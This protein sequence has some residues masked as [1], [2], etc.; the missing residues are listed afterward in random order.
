MRIRISQKRKIVPL[1][2]DP[3]LSPKPPEILSIYRAAVLLHRAG[4]ITLRESALGYQSG[5]GP[6]AYVSPAADMEEVGHLDCDW[7]KIRRFV[8]LLSEE[9]DSAC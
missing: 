2:P 8:K 5:E 3:N 1:I 4:L 9:L 7:V 6:L